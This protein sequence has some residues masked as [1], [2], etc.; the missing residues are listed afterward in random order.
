MRTQPI[1]TGTYLYKKSNLPFYLLH[2][3]KPR[4]RQRKN[5][6]PGLMA[7]LLITQLAIV[8]R[9]QD[10]AAKDTGTGNAA[11]PTMADFLKLQKDVREQRQLIVEMLQSEQQR[12][13]MLLRLLRVQGVAGAVPAEAIRL[14]AIAPAETGADTPP[15]AAAGRLDVAPGPAGHGRGPG[16][17]S[18]SGKVGMTGGDIADAYVFIENVK[19]PPVRGK[20]LEIR[21][22]N[23]QFSPRLAVVQA[24]TSVVFPNF[25][26]VYHNVFSNS[27]RNSFDLGS[28]RAGDT[29]HPVTLTKPGVV[30]VFCNMHQKMSASVLV[31]PSPLY[32]KVRA[33]GTFRIDNVPLGDR[34]VVAWSPRAKS[35]EKRVDVTPSGA[36]VTFAL[37]SDDRKAHLNKLGQAYGSYR[38]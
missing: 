3:L 15:S 25:D 1:N 28:S 2:T 33:D 12:Y 37:E 17:G 38:E 24:G 10:P 19:S 32:A 34:K 4:L 30:E 7:G 8:A 16:R 31:V 5:L 18:V 36:E 11:G 9:A 27:P 35:S 13:D 6:L 20:R 26:T 22:E 14:P 21:Q 23:K 29:P